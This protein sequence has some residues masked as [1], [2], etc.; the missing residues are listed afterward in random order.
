MAAAR[1]ALAAL[2]AAD[3]G[4]SAGI[5]EINEEEDHPSRS[6]P[7]VSAAS[8]VA[9]FSR[10][11]VTEADRR[12]PRL[13]LL[14]FDQAA[15]LNLQYSCHNAVLFAPLWGN[16]PVAACAQEQQAIGRVHRPGQQ[17]D[18]NIYRIELRGPQG[19]ATIDEEIL[20]RNTSQKL[21]AAATSN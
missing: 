16:D 14:N 7:S 6:P 8:Q 19:Q 17:Q 12:S 4:G 11:D 2:L 1:K 3:G 21:I 9:A 18:V 13:L 5:A 15:G 20:A 10:P